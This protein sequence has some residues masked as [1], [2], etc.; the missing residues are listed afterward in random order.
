M[1]ARAVTEIPGPAELIEVAPNVF[2]A[3]VPLP[4]KLDHI[5]VWLFRE[6]D[7]YSVIDTGMYTGPAKSTWTS[8]I[9]ALP[10]GSQ[11]RR[12]F[13]THL[14]EDHVGMVGWLVEQGAS[15]FWMTR[16][17]YLTCRALA[18]EC[19]DDTVPEDFVAFHQGSGWPESAIH[20]YHNHYVIYGK[21][22]SRLPRAYFRLEEGQH[23]VIGGHSWTIVTG[24]GHSPE[25]ACFYCKELELLI[26]GDQV[27]PGISSNVSV[28]PMEPRANPMA[29]WLRSLRKLKAEVPDNVLVLPGHQRCFMGL[30]K[31]ID[32]LIADQEHAFVSLRAA[33]RQGPKRVVDIFEVLFLRAISEEDFMIFNLATGE[34]RACLNY[35]Y[36]LG[37]V[38]CSTDSHGVLWYWIE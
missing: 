29:D 32:S 26:S 13:V 31:R 35:L 21:S 14:H 23:H 5:N 16:M 37:E 15:E 3:R 20:S 36:D 4:S 25:H 10:A 9:D 8:L 19:R 7:G 6:E 27:L 30:H 1:K 33:L 11:I 24:N 28:T 17:E 38:V 2:W 18:A 34:A 22:V 12:V